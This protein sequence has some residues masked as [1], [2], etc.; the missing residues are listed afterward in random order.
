MSTDGLNADIAWSKYLSS[1]KLLNEK[2]GCL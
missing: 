1:W 2:D